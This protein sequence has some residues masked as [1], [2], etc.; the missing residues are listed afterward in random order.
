M[1]GG[2]DYKEY[3]KTKNIYGI[4]TTNVS[5]IKV[6]KENN[7]NAI[8]KLTNT[9]AN[10][11]EEKANEL[12]NEK[13][14]N[15]LTGILIGRKENLDKDVQNVFRKS[16]LSHMLA[17]SGAHVSYVLI[18][19]SFVVVKSKIAKNVGRIITILFLIIFLF[20]TGQTPSVTRACIMSIYL[21]VGSILNKRV[22]TIASISFS[23]LVIVILNP[24]SI[25]D[26]GMQLSYGGTL[27]IVLIYPNLKKWLI[28]KTETKII[29][30]V[31]NKLQELVLI[32]LSANIILI[33][34]ILY[35]YNTLSFSFIISNLLASPIMGVLV[36]LGFVSIILFLIFPFLGNL[37]SIILSIFLDLF[38]KIATITSNL[39]GSQVIIATPKIE[40]IFI[41]YMVI[42]LFFYYKNLKGK[43]IKRKIERRILNKFEKITK[44]KVIATFLILLTMFLFYKQIPKNLRINFIDVGQGDSTL[45]VTP[46]NRRILIDGGGTLK[47]EIFDV[48]KETL[49]PFL[50]D[51]GITKIDYII[52]SHFD[53]DHVR[54]DY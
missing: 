27:G 41:Y 43:N 34:I 11:I 3:L 48:G 44:K 35:H 53:S 30:K 31:K 9:M 12:L 49:I 33:P 8:L 5:Q 10:K 47:K 24:Y 38:L 45:V 46:K 23:F 25:L 14:A 15:V 6:E 37:F 20:L 13:E 29:K 22:S 40:V 36:I 1:R 42:F 32:T 4:V 50:L 54:T 17:V 28:K 26:I 19:I 51:K 21:I 7:I 2:F 16:S 18:G 52:I 39:P